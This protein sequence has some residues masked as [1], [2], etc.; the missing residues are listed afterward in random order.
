MKL[1]STSSTLSPMAVGA[2]GGSVAAPSPLM[3]V[4]YRSRYACAAW[5]T[6]ESMWCT[7][8]VS[9]A[10]RLI[11]SSFRASARRSTKSTLSTFSGT[12]GSGIADTLSASASEIFSANIGGM[13][14]AK[15]IEIGGTTR[16]AA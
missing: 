13:Y 15:S 12:G 7:F 4:V 8:D 5:L 10:P 9:S 11:T 14:F 16:Y 3:N 6:C 1:A 2:G